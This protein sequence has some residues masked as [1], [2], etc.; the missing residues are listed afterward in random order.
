MHVPEVSSQSRSPTPSSP[1][2]FST[3]VT[4]GIFFG[5]SCEIFPHLRR[6]FSMESFHSSREVNCNKM[7]ELLQDFILEFQNG[8]KSL[9]CI[10]LAEVRQMSWHLSRC[11]L[12]LLVLP[13]EVAICLPQ[14]LQLAVSLLC[15]VKYVHA[16]ALHAVKQKQGLA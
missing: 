7:E 1:H 2:I 13:L 4:S 16:R 9:G 6:E 5:N 3:N 12:M 11:F 15:L 10:L 14:I 8:P